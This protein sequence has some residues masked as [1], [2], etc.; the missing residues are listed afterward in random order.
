M[1]DQK[2]SEL[3]NITGAN[4]ANADEFVVV[5]VSADQTKAV[6]RSEFFEETPSINVTGNIT[7]TGDVT[8]G[9]DLFITGPNPKITIRNTRSDSNWDVEPVFGSLDW[10]K[11]DGSGAGTGVM[12]SIQVVSPTATGA[13]AEMVFSIGTGVTNNF[14][15]MRIDSAGNLLVAKTLADGGATAGF[16]VT[17]NGR[18]NATR[19][20]SISG[21]FNR[22][23]SDGSVV[24][25]RKDGTVVGTISVT[26]S[27][28]AY[29]TSS[30]YRLKENI[31]PVQG[32]A[33]VVMAMQP[34]TYTAIADGLWYDGFLAHELQEVHPRA[35]QGTKDAMMDEEYEITPAV[36]EDVIT[37]AVEAV[38][39]TY[40]DEGIELTPA[41]EATPEITK[42]VLV[43][44]AVMG[45]R[46]VPDM[47]SVDYSKLTPILTAALQEALTKIDALE[48]RI[49]SLEG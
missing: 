45:T 39:A 3:T 14:E 1:A 6:T 8:I 9:D 21:V 38:A 4:L 31:T 16:E 15:A 18:I 29:N 22:L 26:A 35:V 2:I 33:D 49:T 28:T 5:D 43:T 24:Q 10:F 27:A 42:S 41:V 48:T 17:T 11:N 13:A 25:L 34:C 44:E 46:S 23:T 32:A 37:P 19:D 12:S 36:Y 20:G 30:D 7:T 47:Q 40:D